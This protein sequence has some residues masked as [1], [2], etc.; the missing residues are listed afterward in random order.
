MLI[1]EQFTNKRESTLK[2]NVLNFY[3][4][5]KFLIVSAIF[6]FLFIIFS[7]IYYF[8]SKEKKRSFLA[9]LYIQAEIDLNNNNKKIAKENLIKIIESNDATYSAL[10]LFLLVNANLIKDDAK[11]VELYEQLLSNN[12]FD[13]EIRNLIIYKKALI[14][15]DIVSE[16]E[17]LNALE[18][19]VNSDSLWKSHALLLLGDYFFSKNEFS[20][21]KESYLKVLSLTDQNNLHGQAQYRLQH[22]S[23]D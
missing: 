11:L 9:D 8:Y 23:Y 3:K 19:I 22:R 12:K 13:K 5:N 4:K 7:G 6:V 10:S 2:E 16:E 21:A 1:K 15:S 17:L 14:Q 18:S 20:K